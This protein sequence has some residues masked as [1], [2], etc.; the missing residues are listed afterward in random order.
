M[1]RGFVTLQQSERK[2]ADILR[3]FSITQIQIYE[4]L[5]RNNLAGVRLFGLILEDNEKAG[6][7]GHPDL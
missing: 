1:C 6:P 5:M 7:F 2:H 3:Q 4:I